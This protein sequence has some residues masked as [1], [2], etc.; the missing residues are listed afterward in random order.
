[1]I[2]FRSHQFDTQARAFCEKLQRESGHQVVCLADESRQSL[3]TAPFEKVSVTPRAA[4]QLNLYCPDN[5]QW[6]CGDYGLYI[7][8]NKYKNERNLWLIEYD[9]RYHSERSIKSVL[10]AFDDSIDFIAPLLSQRQN[11]WWWYAS[12]SSKSKS[13][14]GCLFPLI[15]VSSSLLELGLNERRRLGKTLLYRL[16]WPN[17]ESFLATYSYASQLSVFRSKFGRDTILYGRKLSL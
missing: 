6:R 2:L 8:A 3:D 15:R 11:D 1:M 13:V 12:M 16:F 7:A 10:D 5:F 14:Y 9:V 4:K 17:D